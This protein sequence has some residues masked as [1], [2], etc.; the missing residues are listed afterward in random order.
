[1]AARMRPGLTKSARHTSTLPFL[2]SACA[3]KSVLLDGIGT[4]PSALLAN[5]LKSTSTL[6]AEILRIQTRVARLLK[7]SSDSE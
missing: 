7:A 3:C 1:M 2:D 6:E 4:G 5:D